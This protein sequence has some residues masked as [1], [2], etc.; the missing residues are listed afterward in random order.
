MSIDVTTGRKRNRSSTSS[1]GSQITFKKACQLLSISDTEDNMSD[2]DET[3]DESTVGQSVTEEQGEHKETVI[4]GDKVNS[5]SGQIAFNMET[6]LA[7]LDKRFAKQEERLSGTINAS[8]EFLHGTIK[9]LQDE[10]SA[11]KTRLETLEEQNDK[12]ERKIQY[13]QRQMDQVKEHAI[14]NEM[15]SR[16]NNI[17]I[18]GLKESESEDTVDKVVEMAKNMMKMTISRDDIET[19]HRLPTKNGE[20]TKPTIVRLRDT[21]TKFSLLKARKILKG[22]GIT[23]AED[24]TPGLLDQFKRIKDSRNTRDVWIWMGKFYVKDCS[25]KIHKFG[26]GET[27]PAFFL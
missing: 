24:V 25:D 7:E 20:G 14:K 6:L 3:M 2:N 10:N 4:D 11:L 15:Y 16:R 8:L 21:E 5:G 1:S 9:D 13:L 12:Q 19:A 22:S 23:L 27:I 17:K 18:Y 26:L